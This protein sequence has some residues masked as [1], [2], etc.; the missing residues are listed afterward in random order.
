ME[1]I[2]Q[3]SKLVKI[4]GRDELLRPVLH[5]SLSLPLDDLF[6]KAITN[7]LI[8]MEDYMFSPGKIESWI[9]I[10]D[11]TNINPN[12]S[13]EKIEQAIKHFITNFPMSLEHIYFLEVN[14]VIKQ[15]GDNILQQQLVK[16]L[17][18]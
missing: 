16:E 4:I 13:T 6:V 5:I 2:P 12:L 10:V 3:Y 17:N 1:E 8:T 7:N 14:L 15:I 18:I 9:A 11:L